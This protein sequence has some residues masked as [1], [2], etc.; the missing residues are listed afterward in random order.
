MNKDKSLL[1]RI[2]PIAIVLAVALVILNNFMLFDRGLKVAEAR[3]I[4]KEK[5][6]PAELKLTKITLA[7]CDF[8]FDIEN[9]IDGLKNQNINITK[10][11][12]FSSNSAEG[13]ELIIKY[14]VERLP[15]IL[16]SGEINKSEQL[17]SYFEEKGEINDNTFIYTALTPPYFNMQ[18]TKIDG[19]VSIIHVVDSSCEKCVDLL[20]I[21]STLREQGVFIQDERLIEYNSK[22]GQD[23]IKKFEIKEI[24]AILISKEIDYYTDVK[25]A[26]A[27]SGAKEKEGFYAIHSTIPPYLDLSQNRIVGL[28]DVIYLTKDDC[29]VCYD[30][31]VNRNILLRFG[32]ALNKEN[33]YDINSP[34]GKQIKQ[35][36]NIKKVPI[37]IV[38]S[39]AQYYPSFG[40]VWKSVGTIESD[41]R[42]V[43]R[44]P[45]VIGT[46]WDIESNEVVESN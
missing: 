26:L 17:A 3:D 38:T 37:I 34:E 35:K 7:D 42:F 33:T 16:V 14:G 39:D 9:A 46:Y 19:I 5:L 22:E 4:M 40:Q 8:C 12:S 24:P 10:E 20:P 18:S 29:P 36:Y 43:M 31:S 32:L 1:N 11:D 44:N 41:G 30:V 15:T 25:D 2:I 28:V 23:L 13:K 27:Q 21:S 6:R 45:E